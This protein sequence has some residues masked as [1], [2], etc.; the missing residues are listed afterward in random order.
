M[1]N[2]ADLASALQKISRISQLPA[3]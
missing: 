3:N 1:A 2:R